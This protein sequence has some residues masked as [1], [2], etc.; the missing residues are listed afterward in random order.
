MLASP[1]SS[2]RFQWKIFPYARVLYTC[3]LLVFFLAAHVL[4]SCTE[5]AFVKD[6]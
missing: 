4:C 1:F 2:L 5:A 6:S 3:S